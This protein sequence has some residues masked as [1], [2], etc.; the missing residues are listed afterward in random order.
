[1]NRRDFVKSLALLAAG[2]SAL[3]AQIAVFEQYY[4]ANT[5][6]ISG[7]LIAMDEIIIS[8]MAGR[9]A[10]VHVQVFGN[11]ELRLNLGLNAFGGVLFWRA[12]PDSKIV[13]SQLG[14]SI[15]C[16]DEGFDVSMLQGGISYLDDKFKR[17]LCP[18]ESL[19][20][21]IT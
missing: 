1:M 5:P 20:G 4:E 2:A 21:A 14:W 13:T 6:K 7:P 8:G 9:S 16:P 18:I 10:R 11:G 15:T 19:A 3:P 12:A 17:Q